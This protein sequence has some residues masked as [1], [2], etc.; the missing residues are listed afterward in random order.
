VK[1]SKYLSRILWAALLL[2]LVVGFGS[3]HAAAPE[4]IGYWTTIDDD[5]KT[6]TSIVKISKSGNKLRGQIVQLINPRDK[7][8]TCKDCSGARKGKPI[9]G[10]E[11]LW[12]LSKDG[13]GWSGGR[14]IDPNNGSEYNCQIELVERGTR[15]K[16]RGF[17]GIPL[18][19]R[20]QVW[21]RAQPPQ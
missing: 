1:K 6:P 21:R 11:I 3:A 14:I 2:V 12:N 20:T 4:P 19:G 13:D 15:L 10:M 7:N 18:L 17:V 8:P 16:V 9:V 5:G